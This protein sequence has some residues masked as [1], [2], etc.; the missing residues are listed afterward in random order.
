MSPTHDQQASAATPDDTPGVTPDVTPGVAPD[1]RPDEAHDATDAGVV[2]P[3]LLDADEDPR[4]PA[5]DET[6]PTATR[7]GDPDPGADDTG[8]LSEPPG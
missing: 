7:P 5:N 4:A 1:V 2:T 8:R 6:T 3:R